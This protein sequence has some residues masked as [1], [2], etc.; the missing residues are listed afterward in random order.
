MEDLMEG[1]FQIVEYENPSSASD[2]VTVLGTAFAIQ[3]PPANS[4][5]YY[6]LTAYHNISESFAKGNPIL[7]RDAHF[8]CYS[9]EI[10]YPDIFH[11]FTGSIFDDFALLKLVADRE[12]HTFVI[13]QTSNPHHCYIRGAARYFSNTLVFTSFKGELFWSEPSAEKRDEKIL[14]LDIDTKSLFDMETGSYVDQQKILGG[15]SG[16]PVII[17]QEEKEI[18]VGLFAHIHPDGSASKCYGIPMESIITKCL[19]PRGLYSTVHTDG[20]S[21]PAMQINSMPDVQ[22]YMDL[23]FNGTRGFSLEDCSLEAKIWNAISN[24][25]YHGFAV[26]ETFYRAIASDNFSQYSY[27]AQVATRYYLAR[28]L[29]KRGKKNAAYEQF[30]QIKEVQRQLSATVNQRITALIAARNAVESAAVDP[31]LQLDQIRQCRDELSDLSTADGIYIANELAS[32]SGRGLTNLFGQLA[33]QDYSYS[34]KNAI[35]DIFAE[36]G[37]LLSKYP[38]PLQK[39]DVVNTAISWLTNLWGIW[40][41][42]DVERLKSD[43]LIGFRQAVK[44][45]NSIFHIQSLIAYSISLLLEENKRQALTGLFLSALLMHASNLKLT[46]EG[47]G[48]L[49]RYIKISYQDVYFIFELY[50]NLHQ[51]DNKIFLEKSSIYNI[52]VNAVVLGGLVQHANSIRDLVYQT[53]G[54]D[55]YLGDVENVMALL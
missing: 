28:L 32:V 14:V 26:D 9:V 19:L 46:H 24:Q 43:V 4:H 18:V 49:L 34:L 44:R 1:L 15:M 23:L 25:F 13:G 48:Q 38:I 17:V 52:G 8:T 53:L 7:V 39:Q 47:I 5:V 29:F 40:E 20:T 11:S 6:L 54:Q 30:S 55:I 2:K 35:K 3:S 27:D 36:H 51:V 50:Y 31:Q 41:R 42:P 16:G 21:G 22:I 33:I 12:Y 37:S 45:Q 10:V